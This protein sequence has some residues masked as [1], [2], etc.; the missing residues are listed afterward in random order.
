MSSGLPEILPDG[1]ETG[2][3]SEW[4]RY[5]DELGAAMHDFE[6]GLSRQNVE[7]LR[8]IQ[9]PRGKPPEI[10]HARW[11]QA[12]QRI[13]ELEFRARALREDLRAESARV[14]GGRRFVQSRPGSG[15]GSSLDISG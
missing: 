6:V 12:Y 9:A 4:T 11:A 15:Y 13:S 5:F 7:P 10:L 14:S 3:L 8:L 2:D 1:E